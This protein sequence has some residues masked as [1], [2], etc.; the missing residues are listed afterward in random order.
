MTALTLNTTT[1]ALK[2]REHITYAF[3]STA[4][5]YG[6]A[7]DGINFESPNEGETHINGDPPRGFIGSFRAELLDLLENFG[8]LPPQYA[9]DEDTGRAFV[10]YKNRLTLIAEGVYEIREFRHHSFKHFIKEKIL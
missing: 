6:C 10:S 8:T 4:R 9:W 3:L 2:N 1:T 7:V 5:E